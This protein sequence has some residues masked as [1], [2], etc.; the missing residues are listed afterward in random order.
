MK[1]ID[2]DKL[3]EVLFEKALHKKYFYFTYKTVESIIDSQT[4]ETDMAENEKHT[5][6]KE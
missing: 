1:L 2:A 4:G 6:I 5:T 3:K